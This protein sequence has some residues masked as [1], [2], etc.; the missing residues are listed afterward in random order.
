[1]AMLNSGVGNAVLFISRKKQTRIL[2]NSLM[3]TRERERERERRGER[4]EREIERL[5]LI[6][7]EKE[8]KSQ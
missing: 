7:L 8:D 3:T 5:R 2:I 6:D 4:G 1:M